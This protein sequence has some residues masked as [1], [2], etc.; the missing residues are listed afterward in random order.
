VHRKIFDALVS[1]ASAAL[2]SAKIGPGMDESTQL[3]PVVNETQKKRVLGYFERGVKENAKVLLAGGEARV[4]GH[5]KGYFVAP[6]L[7]TGSPDNVCAREEIFGPAAFVIPF[8]E[9]SEAIELTNRLPYGLANSVWSSDLSRANRVAESLVAGNSW[10]NAHNVFAY[11]LPYGGYNLSG[12]GGGVNSPE[13]LLDYL[14]PQT[15]AR[16]L[17]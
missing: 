8:A 14:R 4:P 1:E 9:E 5:E 12:L 7:L 16:P 2:T 11:G 3:G 6:Y 15:I 17:A 13:T 10:I